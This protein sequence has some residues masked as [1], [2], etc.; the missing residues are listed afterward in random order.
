MSIEKTSEV[1]YVPEHLV[2]ALLDHP[3]FHKWVHHFQSCS[4]RAAYIVVLKDRIL[5]NK[6]DENSRAFQQATAGEFLQHFALQS[7]DAGTEPA[8]TKNASPA[9]L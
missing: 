2:P 8:T 6:T 5:H 4:G 7:G 1:A 9:A 3:D